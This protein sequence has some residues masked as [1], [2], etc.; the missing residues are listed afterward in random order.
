MMWT[1]ETE[2]S[3]DHATMD[4]GSPK[5]IGGINWVMEYCKNQ[6]IDLKNL[7][8]EINNEAFRFGIGKI[9]PTLYVVEL[10]FSFKDIDSE[11][12]TV[13]VKVSV[14]EAKIP[15]LVGRHFHRKKGGFDGKEVKD[16]IE[17]VVS[18]C[19]VCQ[20][21][22]ISYSVPKV[23]MTMSKTFNDVV[24]LDLKKWKVPKKN[25]LYIIDSFSRFTVGVVLKDGTGKEVAKGLESQW[26]TKFGAPNKFWSDN[27]TEFTNEDIKELCEKWGTETDF[28]PPYSPFSNGLNERNHYSCDVILSKILEDHPKMELQQALNMAIW[29]HNTNYNKDG[30]SPLQIVTGRS[31]S[32]PGIVTKTPEKSTIEFFQERVQDQ[33]I[34]LESE[35]RK[36]IRLA[37]KSNCE[38]YMEEVFNEGDKVVYQ[39]K[40]EKKWLGPVEV[41]EQVNDIEVKLLVEEAQGGV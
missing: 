19:D 39:A 38:E 36:K 30:F 16:M 17:E 21:K 7:K 13:M 14:L 10:P 25:I 31:P 8:K 28:G 15:L 29:S 3:D 32:F 34:F 1:T 11:I 18:T 23:S 40:D 35:Y 6:N 5:D 24:T 9:W 4:S 37:E 27:G 41:L 20:K 33:K 12:F 2:G 22:R 26:I